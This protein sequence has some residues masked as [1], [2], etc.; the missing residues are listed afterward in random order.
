MNRG[1]EAASD[2]SKVDAIA[3]TLFSRIIPMR[4]RP[5]KL[6]VGSLRR[7][8]RMRLKYIWDQRFARWSGKTVA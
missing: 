8:A 7:L 6:F 4:Y 2:S 5:R 1:E 3:I